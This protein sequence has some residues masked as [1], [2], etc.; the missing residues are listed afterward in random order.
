MGAL[1][2]DAANA[3]PRLGNL[4]ATADSPSRNETYCALRAR[5]DG[6]QLYFAIA[7]G[8]DSK[9]DLQRAGPTLLGRFDLARERMLAPIDV[10]RVGD[11]AGT[12]D[13]LV[14]DGGDVFFTTDAER[15]GLVSVDSGRVRRFGGLPGEYSAIVRGP[16]HDSLLAG[17]D[18]EAEELAVLRLGAEGRLLAEYR[19]DVT[20][21]GV[22]GIRSLVY[23]PLRGETWILAEL[24]DAPQMRLLIAL[25]THGR[26]LWRVSAEIDHLRSTAGGLRWIEVRGRRLALASLE[27]DASVTPPEASE[28]TL[29]DSRFAAGLDSVEDLWISSNGES[30]VTRRSGWVHIVS[31][32]GGVAR[33]RMPHV[34]APGGYVSTVKWGGRLCATYCGGITV[35]C[36]SAPQ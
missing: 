20:G 17:F 4:I 25:D 14:R 6:D 23:E 15:P 10:G 24:A 11:R 26:V 12:R 33:A 31:P 7:A 16:D 36:R 35:A 5:P 27:S 28:R 18:R 34:E 21:L 29:L 3:A 32:S 8:R 9:I 1:S 22:A 30:V 2:P 13:L 19:I